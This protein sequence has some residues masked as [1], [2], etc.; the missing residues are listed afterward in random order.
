MID[1]TPIHD[2][3]PPTRILDL[4]VVVNDTINEVTLRWTAPG[5]DFDHGRAHKYEAV[6]SP[7]WRKARAFQG[8]KLSPLPDP[9]PAGKLHITKFDFKRFEEVSKIIFSCVNN[10]FNKVFI[11]LINY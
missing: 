1:P 8:N 9:L 11:K 2:N 7:N 6:V 10:L 5:D 4:R 3:I